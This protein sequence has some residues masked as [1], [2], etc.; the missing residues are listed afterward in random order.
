MAKH[1]AND[2]IEDGAL[3][4][5]MELELHLTGI[6]LKGNEVPLPRKMLEWA[7]HED[8]IDG[9]RAVVDV[10]SMKVLI[11]TLK[12]DIDFGIQD[13]LSLLKN[14]HPTTPGQELRVTRNV[15]N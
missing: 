5:P 2:L 14:F 1:R 13:G 7:I 4:L 3:E 8:H 12:V 9:F 6:F 10:S 11:N 15:G